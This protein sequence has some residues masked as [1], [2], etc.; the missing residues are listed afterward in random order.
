MISEAEGVWLDLGTTYAL[1]SCP[2][3]SSSI[4]ITAASATAG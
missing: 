1:G 3:T 2:A 4:P